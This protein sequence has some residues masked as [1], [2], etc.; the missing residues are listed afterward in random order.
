MGYKIF[1]SYKYADDCIYPLSNLVSIFSF[2]RSTVR[3]YV[4]K[5]ESYF[6]HTVVQNEK[7]E[8]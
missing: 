4:D 5:L 6:D 3:D 2:N 7:C 1:V 8:K